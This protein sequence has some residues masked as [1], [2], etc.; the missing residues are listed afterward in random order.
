MGTKDKV[1][2]T[3]QDIKGK[4]KDAVGKATGNEQ[5]ERKGRRDQAKSAMKDVGEKVKEAASSL[6]DTATR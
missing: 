2:N 1:S 6:K 3:A 4:V 5:L